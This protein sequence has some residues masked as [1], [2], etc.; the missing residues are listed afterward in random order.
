[1]AAIALGPLLRDLGNA[2]ERLV[3]A[4][5]GIAVAPSAV[6]GAHG[7]ARQRLVGSHLRNLEQHAGAVIGPAVVAADDVALVGP[8]LRQLRGAVAAA[9]LQ[10]RRLALIVE[11]QDDV[12]A[13][14]LERLRP[15]LE[16]VELL[17]RVPEATEDF[18][19]G[20]QHAPILLIIRRFLPRFAPTWH[21]AGEMQARNTRPLL[22]TKAIRGEC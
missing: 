4:D 16:G 10:G 6:I 7:D 19:L 13:E 9:V 22:Q 8:A 11:E 21:G 12:L 14:Q 20:G 5:P 18:L 1:D 17:G 15:I 2:G 3:E